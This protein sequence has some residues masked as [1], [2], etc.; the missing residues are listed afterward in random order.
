MSGMLTSACLGGF[1]L[2]LSFDRALA[3]SSRDNDAFC[4]C[5]CRRFR[6]RRTDTKPDASEDDGNA[7]QCGHNTL[8]EIFG[9]D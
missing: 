8:L 5:S 6:A 7:R 9:A 4:N 3:N 2:F 1:M